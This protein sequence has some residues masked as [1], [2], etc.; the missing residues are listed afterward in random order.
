[1]LIDRMK[2]QEGCNIFSVV[3]TIKLSLVTMIPWKVLYRI[4]NFMQLN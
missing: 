3:P 1:M 4:G 2:E